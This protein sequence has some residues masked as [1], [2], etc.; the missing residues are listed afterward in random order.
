MSKVIA[1]GIYCGHII[2][3]EAIKEDQRVVVTFDG[4][5]IPEL[6]EHFNE[7]ISKQHPI[8][9]TYYPDN[10]S[11]LAAYNV[12]S[13]TFFDSLKKITIEGEIEEIP[14]EQGKIY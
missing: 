7:L 12:L 8:S 5:D 14:F 1:T 10:N 11:L 6:R 3:V 4:R 9:G 2:T 13:T